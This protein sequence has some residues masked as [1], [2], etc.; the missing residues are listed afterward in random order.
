M[1]KFLAIIL[2]L[3]FVLSMATVSFAATTITEDKWEWISLG[4]NAT[5]PS[6]PQ[7]ELIGRAKNAYAMMNDKVDA[8]TVWVELAQ[9]ASYRANEQHV[10]ESG[11]YF[12]ADVQGVDWVEEKQ[13]Y[14]EAD[15]NDAYLVVLNNS[16]HDVIL[17]RVTDNVK[18]ELVSEDIDTLFALSDPS[19]IGKVGLAANFTADGKVT[20]NATVGEQTKKVFDYAETGTAPTGDDVVL[21]VHF[22]AYTSANNGDFD[23]AE[24]SDYSAEAGNPEMGDTTAIVAVVAITALQAQ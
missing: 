22:A 7:M 20:V 21:H 9:H 1:K 13:K 16:T 12:K 24:F 3:I 6:A 18:T 15:V 23:H 10:Y 8:G 19:A 4:M 2:S 11:F 5:Y 17:Y 14:T